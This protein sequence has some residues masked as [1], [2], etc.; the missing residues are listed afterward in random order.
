MSRPTACLTLLSLAWLAGAPA[1]AAPAFTATEM[2]R[3][4]RLAEPQLAPDGAAV[5]YT[6]TEIDL[7][8][9]TRNA[10]LWLAPIAG[11]EPRRLTSDKASDTRPRF[12]PDGK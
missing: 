11:G 6:L 4:K 2:M 3:L 12:S 5:A 8:G 1:D 10:D 7:A 9:A